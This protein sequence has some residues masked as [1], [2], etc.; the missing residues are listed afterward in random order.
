MNSTK[1][2]I[3]LTLEGDLLQVFRA[4]VSEFSE[5]GKVEKVLLGANGDK[6]NIKLNEVDFLCEGIPYSEHIKPPCRKIVRFRGSD[7]PSSGDA[8]PGNKAVD[9]I[10]IS[11]A[12]WLTNCVCRQFSGT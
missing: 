10:R 5:C 1:P 8:I 9:S 7:S 12:L 2:R 6:K 4:V 11:L 3:K